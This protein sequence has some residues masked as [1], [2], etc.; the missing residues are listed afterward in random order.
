M[1]QGFEYHT[2]FNSKTSG[3]NIMITKPQAQ[4]PKIRSIARAWIYAPVMATSFLA[5]AQP[6]YA[7]IDNTATANGTYSGNPV[8]SAPDSV[9]IP[10]VTANPSLSIA[11][12][13]GTAA[14]VA[15]GVNATITDGGD[16][17]VYHYIITNNGNVTI[18]G[19]TPVD[20]GPLFG[21]AQVAGTGSMSGFTLTSGTTT[22][23]PGQAAEFDA[24]YTLSTLDVYRSA[25]IIV[26]A[27]AVNNSSTGTGLPPIGPAIVSPAGT[28]TTTIAAGPL[29]TVSKAGVL[30]DTNGSVALQAE[31]GETI[32]YT[33]TVVNTGN[34]A[35]TGIVI[36]DTHE[37]ALVPQASFT[38]GGLS[39]GP[40]APGTISSD[41]AVNGSWD[42]LQPGAT[43]TF[44]YV[45][46]VTQAEVDGG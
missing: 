22:L 20:A 41:A 19:V 42:T 17:I 3:E 35:I 32:T 26:P 24:T 13:I 28:A 14:T 27:N 5:L 36:N 4:S 8:T 44:T 11:K 12:S 7:D 38:E 9:N 46:T 45:H 1:S 43:I 33:Y 25:G 31:V 37:L 15:A 40:L 6:T 16:T 18:T 29:L 30:D 23:L 2:A 21:T 39:D 10:V 34:V